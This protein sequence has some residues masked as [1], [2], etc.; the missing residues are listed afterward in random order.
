MAGVHQTRY[1]PGIDGLR[2]IAV[3]AVLFEHYAGRVADIVFPFGAGN[4][5]VN[6]FFVISGFL[7]T[8][9]LLD[10][11]AGS[12]HRGRSWAAFH[13]RRVFR[14]APMLIA[15]IAALW[16]LAVPV[17]RDSWLWHVT[18]LSNVYTAAGGHKLI[19]WTLAV[20][21]QFYLV[22]PPIL[23]L[24]PRRYLPRLCIALIV[25]A[26][27][28][29]TALAAAGIGRGWANLM[30]IGNL[31]PLAIGALLALAAR[32]GDARFTLDWLTPR[33]RQACWL[34][35]G[36]CFV[37]VTAI[38]LAFGDAGLPRYLLLD[39]LTGTMG[40]ALV[41]IAA[42]TTHGLVPQLLTHR[43]MLGIGK[44]SYSVYLLHNW[45]PDLLERAAGPL[46]RVIAARAVYSP[47]AN[48]P[49]EFF[50]PMKAK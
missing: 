29:K 36:L 20:E 27:G 43:M 24:T 26:I 7:I 35:A 22:W 41:V 5:G 28:W 25:L 39:L 11:L 46:P 8:G 38:T 9:I 50:L 44:I 33:L 1:I 18:Y 31:E 49:L 17:I 2:A 12:A 23:M 19:F 42:S 32:R 6:L 47:T 14:L 3:L 4:F 34:I 40:G 15:T 13:V 48:A 10:T 45:M 37:M 21:E 30:L 16:L